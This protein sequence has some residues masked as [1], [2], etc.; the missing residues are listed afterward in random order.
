M[1]MFSASIETATKCLECGGVMWV[2]SA[3]A[4]C[5]LKQERKLLI[6]AEAEV[7][8]LNHDL[9]MLR[10]STEQYPNLSEQLP[11]DEK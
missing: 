1:K 4:L 11:F 5:H 3:C 9:E 2:G 6:E 10:Q 7:E 8:R